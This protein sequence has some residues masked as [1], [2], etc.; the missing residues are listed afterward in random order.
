MVVGPFSVRKQLRYSRERCRLPKWGYG[1]KFAAFRRQ[2]WADL[3]AIRVDNDF[4]AA[5]FGSARWGIIV[6]D[7]VVWAMSN[8][9]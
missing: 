5:I 6:G 4:Y 1:S 2:H 8:D 7:W 3:E 9:K